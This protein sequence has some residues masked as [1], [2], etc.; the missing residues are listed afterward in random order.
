MRTT[1]A[2]QTFYA[3]TAQPPTL[4]GQGEEG[5][6]LGKGMQQKCYQAVSDGQ[7]C[8]VNHWLDVQGSIK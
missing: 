3:K 5:E 4:G 6:A 2:G 1:W 7:R 8:E